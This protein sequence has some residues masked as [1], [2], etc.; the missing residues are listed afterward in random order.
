MEIYINR[1]SATTQI[2]IVMDY[3]I[4]M[5]EKYLYFRKRK[6]KYLARTFFTHPIEVLDPC[7]LEI[8]FELRVFQR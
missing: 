8:L 4:M 2:F 7:T 3:L 5:S 1:L 6:K